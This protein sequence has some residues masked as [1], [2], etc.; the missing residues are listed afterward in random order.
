MLIT[1]ETLALSKLLDGSLNMNHL[2]ICVACITSVVTLSAHT[3]TG[4]VQT[5]SG[6][7]VPGAT[8]RVLGTSRGA[9]AAKNGS[10]SIA[11]V[12]APLQL[13]CTA[14][15]YD[16]TLV[17]VTEITNAPIRIV[18]S[19]RALQGHPVHVVADRGLERSYANEATIMEV[20]SAE[21]LEAASALNL[22][23][24]LNFQPGIRTENN[25]RNCGFT[26]VRI[27]GLA[28]PYTRMLLNGR[29]VLSALLGV[30]GLEQIP[31]VMI[32][33]VEIQ[34]GAADISG[35]PGSIAGSVNIITR[36]TSSNV[37]SAS[38]QATSMPQGA[39]DRSA[40]LFASTSLNSDGTSGVMAFATSRHRDAFD[41]D[42]DGFS[43][44]PL[45]ALDAGGLGVDV[46][47]ADGHKLSTSAQWIREARRGGDNLDRAPFEA[48]ITEGLDH[49]IAGGTARYTAVLSAH[50]L[51]SVDGGA[52]H[53]S[54]QSY[55]GGLGPDPTAQD[56]LLAQTYF[57][58]TTDALINA[59]ARFDFQHSLFDSDIS[60]WTGGIDVIRNDVRDAMPGR[61]RLID[62]TTTTSGAYAQ[63]RTTGMPLGADGTW[64]WQAGV[65][66][67]VLSID[68][69]Y[70]TGANAEWQTDRTL[71]ALTPRLSVDLR[72]SDG[73]TWRFGYAS[74]FRGPQAFDEDLHVSTLGGEARVVRLAP[75]LQPERSHSLTL[76]RVRETEA[77][78][79]YTLDGF[80][81]LLQRPFLIAL[82][83]DVLESGAA[84]AEKRNG[85]AAIVYG[86]NAEVRYDNGTVTRRADVQMQAG[87][88]VQQGR[89]SAVGGEVIIE[90]DGNQ[91]RSS[92][93]VRMPEVYGSWLCTWLPHTALSVATSGIVTGPMD[94]P[95]ERTVTIV[96]TPWMV[97]VSMQATWWLNVSDQVN[98]GVTLAVLN[99][100]DVFQRDIEQGPM[101]DGA[102]SY[103]PMRPRSIRLGLTTGMGLR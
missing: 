100:F 88:T 94:M 16:T 41:R 59:A 60:I 90:Q 99:V 79:G 29:P 1:E 21:H 28:G 82:T 86:L 6:T 91:V 17:A 65:R 5:S 23:D 39:T 48:A 92:R 38:A 73:E 19:D 68:G 74:G 98:L 40:N 15:G 81:T 97:D 76:S 66:L 89:Y 67:D 87:V 96:R 36:Q 46:S 75:T 56:S 37:V 55:Y 84:V 43:D 13:R 69:T 57:G 14:V 63:M 2:L 8:I 80:A 93:F 71:A 11:G 44:I 34:R 72:P 53:T 101:R 95:N 12:E 10:F 54:R 18:L 102:F 32:D 58:V 50:S 24:G 52:M 77:G 33:R 47:L 85:S 3:L 103:G 30:Y 35:G 25:C 78:F 4:V 7:P 42:G 83:D 49:A 70:L 31:T 61:D 62:Q 27:N 22:A 20:T 51:L 9:V 64:G 45:L 26:Q